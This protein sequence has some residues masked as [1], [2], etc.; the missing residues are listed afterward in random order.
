[1]SDQY[2]VPQ[3]LETEEKIIGPFTLKQFFYLMGAGILIYVFFNMFFTT[4]VM[5]F[6]GLSAGVALI[7]IVLVFVKVNERPFEGF[8]LYFVEYVRAPKEI[9][10]EKATRIKNLTPMVQTSAQEGQ[11]QR[12]L[13]KQA[14][15]GIVKSQLNELAMILDTKGWTQTNVDNITRGR[16][17]SSRVAQSQVM[18]NLTS[19][20][21]QLDDVFADLENALEGVQEVAKEEEMEESLGN[22]LKVRLQ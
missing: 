13:S 20:E 21:G 22:I 1:M 4:S 7:A 9:K 18:Q 3:N 17:V 15:K 11:K 2:K 10:W 16:I 6:A 5:L 12:E 19:S 14:K 8:L